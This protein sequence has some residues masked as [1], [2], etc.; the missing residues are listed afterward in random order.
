MRSLH[1]VFHPSILTHTH[2]HTHVI[3]CSHP[4]SPLEPA[5]PRLSTTHAQ[6]A[7][8]ERVRPQGLRRAIE[9]RAHAV[10]GAAAADA[11]QRA[12][13]PAGDARAP[14]QGDGGA[15]APEHARAQLEHDPDEPDATGMSPR[16][17]RGRCSRRMFRKAQRQ[18]P[19]QARDEEDPADD[20]EHIS[21]R[22]LAMTRYKRN[23]ELMNEV[24][25]FAAFGSYFS[26]PGSSANLV[27]M[28]RRRQ[29]HRK[30]PTSVLDIRQDKTRRRRR[31][32]CAFP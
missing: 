11:V 21:T 27:L 20:L 10:P 16:S 12:R 17:I 1:L 6:R 8:P 14:E 13:R 24:F 30:A 9:R 3:C 22:T 19:P 18:A 23:H 7:L 15:R 28:R 26:R 32:S 31:E 2:A 29:T 5:H 4:A 25:M